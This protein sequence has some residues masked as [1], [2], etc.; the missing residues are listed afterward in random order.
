MLLITNTG[1]RIRAFKRTQNHWFQ[2]ITIDGKIVFT[3]ETVNQGSATGLQGD[4]S[5]P[6]G[7]GSGVAVRSRR[8]GAT[9]RL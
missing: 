5:S 1:R 6:R 8:P 3:M 2:V 7:A 9:T 4:R